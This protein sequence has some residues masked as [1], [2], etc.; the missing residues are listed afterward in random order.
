MS[1]TRLTSGFN[2]KKSKFK[3]NKLK[4]ISKENRQKRTHVRINYEE[5]CIN[6]CLM[7]DCLVW[8]RAKVKFCTN[9][10]PKQV[11][12]VPRCNLQ[13]GRCV[14]IQ[15]FFLKTSAFLNNALHV[16][17]HSFS[18]WL[19]HTLPLRVECNKNYAK[20]GLRKFHTSSMSL[21]RKSKRQPLFPFSWI[22]LLYSPRKWAIYQTRLL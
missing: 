19:L 22:N 15:F 2:Y 1:H 13:K 16:E 5:L 14:I 17:V 20:G 3:V 7:E 18:C 12:H 8:K 10:T 4:V 9:N 11:N 6:K 21:A